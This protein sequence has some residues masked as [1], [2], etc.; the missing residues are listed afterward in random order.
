MAATF[1]DS[2]VFG[3]ATFYNLFMLKPQGEHTCVVCLGTAC[4]IKGA[5]Q[6][7]TAVEQAAEIRKGETTPDKQ[8]S[9]LVAR[10]L[11][12]CGLAPA[13]AVA[14]VLL[15]VTLPLIAVV[16][17]VVLTRHNHPQLRLFLASWYCLLLGFPITMLANQGV[18]DRAPSMASPASLITPLELKGCG[19]STLM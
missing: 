4:Y 18:A 7:L 3:V 13:V 14:L 6:I 2:R 17:L 1:S 16:A 12:T 5:P 15:V 11:G 19:P 8:V 9:L 10:C